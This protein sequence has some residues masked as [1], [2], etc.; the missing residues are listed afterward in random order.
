MSDDFQEITPGIYLYLHPEQKKVIAEFF[1]EELEKDIEL[2]DS[3]ECEITGTTKDAKS[4]RQFKKITGMK[5]NEKKLPRKYI[6]GWDKK[7]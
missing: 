6:R 7:Y 4:I 3:T 1:E 2:L 5:V